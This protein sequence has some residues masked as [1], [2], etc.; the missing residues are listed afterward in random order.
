[1][2]RLF[3]SRL[4][5]R[6]HKNDDLKELFFEAIKAIENKSSPMVLTEKDSTSEKILTPDNRLF[7]HIPYHPR[8]IFTK[9]SRDGGKLGM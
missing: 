4:L 6:G 3:Y 2:V 8:D 9:L 7:F 5:A 1:M